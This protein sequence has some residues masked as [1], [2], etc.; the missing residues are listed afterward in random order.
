MIIIPDILITHFGRKPFDNWAI[1]VRNGRI[2]KIGPSKAVRQQFPRDHTE[3]LSECV[4]L[5]GLVN[6][7]AHLELP[8]LTRSGGS[9]SYAGWVLCLLKAKKKLSFDAYR[10]A[11]R[12]NIRSLIES[13]TTTVAEI[14]THETSPVCIVRSG[15]RSVIFH[16]I[17]SLQPGDRSRQVIPGALR[18][19]SRIMHGL[20]PHSPHTVS[21]GVLAGL[22]AHARKKGLPLCMHVAETREERLF[23]QG[24]PSD[25]ERLYHSAGWRREWAPRGRSSIDYLSRAGVLGRSFLAVHAVDADEH[26]IRLL[27]NSGAAVAHCPRSNRRMGVGTMPLRRMLDAGIA[28]GLGTDSL[29][30]VPT[31]NMWDEMRA[32]LQ[33][34]RGD[35]LTA[36]EILRLAT[37][38]GA[39]ALGMQDRIGTLEPGKAA[40]M[41]AVPLPRRRTDDLC[42]DLLRE[43]KSSSMTMVN[44]T[45][46]LKTASR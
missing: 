40:D 1:V 22:Y 39:K 27:R 24:R 2:E 26:D 21:Q 30:S 23:L 41:I 43:T 32:A 45:I 46:L 35:G 33:V 5:P 44:G 38:G 14:T 7:H 34:H 15:I 6:V 12:E 17:I 31:L 3:V 10:R 8:L 19:S 11:C 37:I 13:G 18:N 20:S 9:H 28:V 25:L 36:K 4:L 16:E 29:A 42:S